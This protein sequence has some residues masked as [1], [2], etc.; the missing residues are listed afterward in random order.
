M[1]KREWKWLDTCSHRYFSGKRSSSLNSTSKLHQAVEVVFFIFAILTG[2]LAIIWVY[3]WS[4]LNNLRLDIHEFVFEMMNEPFPIFDCVLGLSIIVHVYVLS[5]VC[6]AFIQIRFHHDLYMALGHKILV[7]LSCLFFIS[8]FVMLDLV[9]PGNTQWYSVAASLEMT[10]PFLQICALYIWVVFFMYYP[11]LLQTVSDDRLKHV[12][13]FAYSSFLLFLLCIPFWL[14]S[15]CIGKAA[16]DLVKPKVFGHRGAPT[17]APENTMLSFQKALECGVY[18]LESDIRIS[19]DGVAFL[20][21]DDTLLRTTNVRSVFPSR[22]NDRP[23]SFTWSELRQLNAGD[24]FFNLP[25]RQSLG[26]ED[27]SLISIQ[28]IPSLKE[29]ISFVSAHNLTILF[30]LLSPPV[31]HLNYSNYLRGV[32]QTLLDSDIPQNNV[33]WPLAYPGNSRYVKNLAPNFRVMVYNVIKNPQSFLIDIFNIQYADVSE[34]MILQ[35][36]VSIIEYVIDT[37]LA[38][39][40]AWCQGAWAVTTNDA[41]LLS[42]VTYPSW[43]LTTAQFYGVWVT[44]ELLCLFFLGFVVYIFRKRFELKERTISPRIAL[45][46]QTSSQL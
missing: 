21:H 16:N 19:R 23:E 3:C 32:L 10:S 1:R 15:P 43:L 18:G 20:M 9:W 28:K 31:N 34:K 26:E 13:M 17:L 4:V 42:S 37:R 40:R 25:F 38:F 46:K 29:W 44:I 36:N 27:K 41:C 2:I 24:W 11:Y 35:C 33:I 39:S 45:V 6:C 7:F 5:V 22:Q 12:M 14:S 30:D 8:S